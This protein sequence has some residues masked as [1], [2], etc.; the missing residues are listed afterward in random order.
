MS[1]L[2]AIFGLI[3]MFTVNA[4]IQFTIPAKIFITMNPQIVVK[5]NNIIMA[6]SITYNPNTLMYNIFIPGRFNRSPGQIVA[7]EHVVGGY[8]QTVY[9]GTIV[10]SK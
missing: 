2:N 7:E 6:P 4:D 3:L 10:L 5:I 9:T 1:L 8:L